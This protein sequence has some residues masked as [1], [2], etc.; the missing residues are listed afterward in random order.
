MKQII[1]LSHFRNICSHNGG[2]KSNCSREKVKSVIDLYNF[3]SG[4]VAFSRT[5]MGKR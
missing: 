5:V 2:N 4:A 1:F 3:R